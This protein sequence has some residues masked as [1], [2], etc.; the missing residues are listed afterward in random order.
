MCDHKRKLSVSA[1]CSDMCSISFPN[2]VSQDDG[3]VPR[4]LGLGGGDY[5]EVN[6][7]I[8]CGVVIDFPEAD[9]VLGI[10]AELKEEQEEKKL[11]YSKK[12]EW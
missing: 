8:D 2:N 4:G 7:C 1:K 9:V 5:L 10:A 11:R 6:I 12:R 3:Y